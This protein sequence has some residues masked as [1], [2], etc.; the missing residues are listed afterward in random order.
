MIVPSHKHRHS[1]AIVPNFPL[2][3]MQLV[4]VSPLPLIIRDK[5]L[6]NGPIVRKKDDNRVLCQYI[7]NAS[8]SISIFIGGISVNDVI[9]SIEAGENFDLITENWPYCLD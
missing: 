6:A 2:V 1:N 3:A 5:A 9:R 4:G 7:T 8:V